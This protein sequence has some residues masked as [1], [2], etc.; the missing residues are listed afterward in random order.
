[1]TTTAYDVG[2]DAALLG[3]EPSD[4]DVSNPVFMAGYEKIVK[5][6]KKGAL[7]RVEEHP[8][9]APELFN[10]ALNWIGVEGLE[11]FGDDQGR[12]HLNVQ[13]QYATRAAL[14]SV[15][16]CVVAHY[17]HELRKSGDTL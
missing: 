13:G 1:M 12:V 11:A 5:E 2:T 6:G 7:L 3:I 14:Y 16:Q 9:K 8:E 4:N 17:V 15:V 10:R